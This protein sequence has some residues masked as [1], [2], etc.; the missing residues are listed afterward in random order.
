MVY[1]TPAALR[2][3]L[4]A[5]LQNESREAGLPLDRLRRRA[6]FERL[7][8]RL[9]VAQPGTWIVKGGLALE[10]R[11]QARARTTRD[12]DLA[13]REAAQDGEALRANLIDALTGDPDQDGFAF[14]VSAPRHLAADES[15]R[16]G[17]RYMI[18]ARLA[19]REFAQVR[20]DVVARTE[21]ISATERLPL[22]GALV[23]A[24]L[25]IRDVEVV[26]TAQV[27]AEKLHALTRKYVTEN[28]RVRD[29]ADLVMVIEDGLVG[30]AALL[31]CVRLVFDA[32]AT[33]PVPD[34]IPDPPPAWADTYAALAADLEVQA[35]SVAD[36]LQLLREY[37]R[38]ARAAAKES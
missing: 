28:S 20:I 18:L 12:L 36:A 9:D 21:E 7:L 29:L 11:W 33:H 13:R 15:G 16:P 32:R 14:E 5:R 8:V 24:G 2:T 23:F 27:F 22:P 38:A 26:A 6:V 19:G 25:P 31:R 37:W 17:W 1:D 4:E 30:D 10:I 34:D 35:R 3:A